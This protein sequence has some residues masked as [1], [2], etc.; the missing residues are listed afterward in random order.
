MPLMRCVSNT[1]LTLSYSP[2]ITDNGVVN[3]VD[4]KN[5]FE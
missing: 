1:L 2:L 4:I 3:F 5:G